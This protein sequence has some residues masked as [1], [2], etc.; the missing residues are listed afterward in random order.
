MIIYLGDSD[1]FLILGI[2][3]KSFICN[4]MLVRS[5]SSKIAMEIPRQKISGMLPMKLGMFPM[6]AAVKGRGTN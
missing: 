4:T 1:P 3:I 5:G 2:L 6:K